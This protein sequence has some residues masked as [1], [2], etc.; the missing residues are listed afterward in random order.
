MKYFL[1]ILSACFLGCKKPP[2]TSPELAR[3]AAPVRDPMTVVVAL[4]ENVEWGHYQFIKEGKHVGLELDLLKHIDEHSKYQFTFIE[5]P[6]KRAMDE[7]QAG[8]IDL[9]ISATASPVRDNIYDYSDEVY[10]IHQVLYYD[11]KRFPEGVD[12]KKQSEISAFQVGAILGYNIDELTFPVRHAGY[13]Q[14]NDMAEAL[15]KGRIDFAVA[16]LEL[17]AFNQHMPKNFAHVL[18]PDHP[19]LICH[20]LIAKDNPRK[21]DILSE[22]NKGLKSLKDSGRYEALEQAYFT[23]E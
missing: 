10:R 6:W 14:L 16:Y 8:N 5:K 12:F 21:K 1:L 3:S 22:L 20:W 17:E 15:A 9:L 13:K 4:E 7:V 2:A 11:K 23:P 18:I 19:P